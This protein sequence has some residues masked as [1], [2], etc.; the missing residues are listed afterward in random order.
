[1]DKEKIYCQELEEWVDRY[2]CACWC[3]EC[4]EPCEEAEG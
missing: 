1:M 2:W 3:E 4:V